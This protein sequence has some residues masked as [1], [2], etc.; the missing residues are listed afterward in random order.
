MSADIASE[1]IHAL[2][3]LVTDF[4]REEREVEASESSIFETRTRDGIERR[5]SVLA[6]R[7]AR[8][9]VGLEGIEGKRSM[10]AAIVFLSHWFS[11]W[12]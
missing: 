10:D 2:I 1:L 5:V 6:E 4:V 9:C 3:D 12:A 11:H 7:Y 8:V